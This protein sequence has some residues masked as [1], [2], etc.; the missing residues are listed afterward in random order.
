MKLIFELASR[1]IDEPDVEKRHKKLVEG[2]MQIEKPWGIDA[3]DYPLP[4]FG[5]GITS[6]FR[7]NKLLGNGIKGDVMYS[8]RRQLCPE[9]DDRIYLEFNPQKIDYALLYR[10]VLPKYITF[11]KPYVASIFNQEVVYYEYDNREKYDLAKYFR[12]NPI[13]FVDEKCCFDK[14][15]I[16]PSELKIRILN[17]VEHTELFG[18]GLIVVVSSRLLNLTESNE[19]HFQMEKAVYGNK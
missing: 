18:N 19:L 5:Q 16:S 17:I 15:G 9:D 6:V 14:M 2:L 4:K 10:K 13:F 8:Y 1:S 3:G 12:F 7:L 11:F